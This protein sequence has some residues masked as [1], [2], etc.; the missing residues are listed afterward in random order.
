MAEKINRTII[1]LTFP[2][3]LTN[4][5]VPVL[6]LCDT[7]IAGHL[8]DGRYIGA[9]SIGAMMLNVLFWLCGFL[10]M[11]TTGLTAQAYG[12]GDDDGMRCVFTRSFFLAVVIGAL[13]FICCIPLCHL[14]LLIIG[15]ENSVRQLASTYFF[16]CI[17]GTPAQLATMSISGWFLGMQNTVRPMIV[18]ISTNIINIALSF[19]AVFYFDL[20]FAGVAYGT[21]T[22]NWCGLILAL[23]LAKQFVSGSRLWAPFSDIFK[24]GTLRRF[25]SVNSDLFFRSACVMGVSLTV[26]ALGARLGWLTLGTNAVMMQF[27]ILFSYFMDGFAFTGE[28]L[29]GKYLGSGNDVM[30]R[31]SVKYLILWSIGMAVTFLAIYTVGWRALVNLLTDV[32]AVRQNVEIY[33]YWLILIPPVTVSAFIFD[34]FFIGLTATRRML[35]VT[36]SAASVFFLIAFV[37]PDSLPHVSLPTND[38]LWLAF[39]CYLFL[40]G[41]LLAVQMPSLLRKHSINKQLQ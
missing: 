40:R 18:A 7:G 28:A 8:G 31:R 20:G 37:H 30:L 21:L 1:R 3:I 27:F 11:G 29:T 15:A 35:F 32:E 26:T 6:G 25:F 5:T 17:F 12:A 9:I 14:L 10:R 16:I 24:G 19:L 13:I 4:I 38:T 39:L 23:L 22:A 41:V 36:M 33:H 34:G 2:S